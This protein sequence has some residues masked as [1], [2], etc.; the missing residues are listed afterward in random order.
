MLVSLRLLARVRHHFGGLL[1]VICSIALGIGVDLLKPW[2]MKLVVDS[3]IGNRPLPGGAGFLTL[4]PGGG[5]AMAL[6]A[7]L[8]VATILLFLT[9][10][11]LRLWQSRLETTLGAR[12]T[13]RLGNDVFDHLQRLSVR[14]HHRQATG[15]L[16]K[17]VV[18]DAACMRDFSMGFMV[19]LFT[20]VVSLL[21]MFVVMWRMDH[22]LAWTAIAVAPFLGLLIHKF[23]RPMQQ[24]MY[25]QYELQGRIMAVSEQIL[26]ALPVVRAFGREEHEDARFSSIA[27]ASD[28]AY[29]GALSSQL[30]F[31][32]V[33]DAILAL[34]TAGLM[35]LGGY[36]VLDGRLSVGSLLVFL[37]YLS[38]LYAP[39]ETLTYLAQTLA[40]ATAGARRVFEVMDAEDRISEQDSPRVLPTTPGQR[41]RRVEFVDV[42]FGYDTGRPIL[43]G[44][45]L[46]ASPGSTIALVGSTG[47]GK[48]TLVSLIPRFFD[49]D[50][51]K[52][53]LDGVDTK[54][55]GI[56]A[57]RSE[58]AMVLQEPFLFPV[59]VAENIAYGR[60]GATREE[61]VA[62]AVA[63][64]A[65]SFIRNLPQGYDTVIAERGS[66]LSG[67]ERQRISIA[68][69]L[70]KDAPVLI[71]DEP[72]SSLDAETEALIMS[73]LE[74][75]M[76][77]RT[78]F[79][80]AH[81][82]STIRR[83]D[84]IAVLEGGSIVERGTHRE[85]MAKDGAYAHLCRL[86]TGEANRRMA[87]A[88]G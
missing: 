29:L 22:I 70:L 88:R 25:E 13:Y 18:N 28:R 85:L 68:R 55:L 35:G 58:I 74:G 34:G 39:L 47:A 63:A 78:T 21:S 8:T 52:V 10:W 46:E 79:V 71:L 15:D 24:R 3:V 82:L 67:G 77:G 49:P 31:K 19:P 1:I 2:P 14:F 54:E 50:R 30:R 38:S 60:P 4:L 84:R 37:S 7:W 41:G 9:R 33:V 44:I 23:A 73:A 11:A 69:A 48:S 12:M 65:D 80:I 17:R 66:T 43:N 6:L 61:I 45:D 53:L 62:A 75:L 51:G 27:R 59:T 64:N 42:S 76:A 16:L 87:E 72:T 20:S 83:A 32:F 40:A 36:A 81:R 57:L 26:T 5:T 86:Q 56:A